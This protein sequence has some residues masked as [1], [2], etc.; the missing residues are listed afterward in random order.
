[1]TLLD[2]LFETVLRISITALLLG[3]FLKQV[4]RAVHSNLVM[5]LPLFDEPARATEC[6][7]QQPEQLARGLHTY[8]E[9]VVVS[10]VSRA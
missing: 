3:R 8:Y 1:M 4:A 9:S 2:T 5:K 10:A 6:S 7:P